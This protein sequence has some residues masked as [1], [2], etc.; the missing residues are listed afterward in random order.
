MQT[1]N[2]RNSVMVDKS[3]LAKVRDTLVMIRDAKFD[4]ADAQQGLSWCQGL[5]KAVLA[6]LG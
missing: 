2:V 1:V 3:H 5:A 6:E 4:P